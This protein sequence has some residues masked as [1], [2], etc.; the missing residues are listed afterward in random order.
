MSDAIPDIVIRLQSA[1][2]PMPPG[3]DVSQMDLDLHVEAA[4][5]LTRLRAENKVLREEVD[6]WREVDR[7]KGEAEV[8]RD[9]TVDEDEPVGLSEANYEISRC[10]AHTNNLRTGVATKGR[11][12]ANTGAENS[13]ESSQRKREENES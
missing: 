5:E 6:A 7:I 3:Y 11:Q 8:G 9:E 10:M 4:A 12:S 2:E 1:G 13:A